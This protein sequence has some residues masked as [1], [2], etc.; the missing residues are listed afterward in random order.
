MPLIRT[1]AGGIVD[2]LLPLNDPLA[3]SPGAAQLLENWRIRNRTLVRRPGVV[4]FAAT[5]TSGTT[6]VTHPELPVLG[7]WGGPVGTETKL[8]TAT[9][10][11]TGTTPSQ[12]VWIYTPASDT[13]THASVTVTTQPAGNVTDL[14]T[15]CSIG[16]TVYLSN[17]VNKTWKWSGSGDIADVVDT[18]TTPITVPPARWLVG[19]FL[20]RLWLLHTLEG[21]ARQPQRVRWCI[22]GNVTNWSDSGAGYEDLTDDPF[23]IT[24]GGVISGRLVVYKG[25]GTGGSIVVGVPTGLADDPVGFETLNPGSG[26]G[27]YAPRTVQTVAGG[28]HIFLGH[29][30]VYVFDGASLL[31]VGH[32]VIRRVLQSINP[33]ALRWAWALYDPTEAEYELHIPL[34]AGDTTPSDRYVFNVRERRWSGYESAEYAHGVRYAETITDTWA[35]ALGAWNAQGDKR[36]IDTTSGILRIYSVYGTDTATYRRGDPAQD[37]DVGTSYSSIYVSRQHTFEGMQVPHG[38]SFRV[39]SFDDV[40]VLRSL[41]LIW[42]DLGAVTW[43]VEVSTDTGETWTTVSDGSARGSGTTRVVRTIF[44]CMISAT[45]F[46]V[47]V[48]AP[49]VTHLIDVEYEIGYAGPTKVPLVAENPP[50]GGTGSWIPGHDPEL[51]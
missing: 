44:G 19:G 48:T 9:Q 1:R 36:W 38:R 42:R 23:P 17:G 12:R 7:L 14:F 25:D 31:P 16:A 47:R 2:G 26:I 18:A 30:D 50:S 49:S 20:E 34:V 6:T 37:T 15:F 40:K 8:F 27:C 32:P 35:T 13:F 11:A 4:L 29:D 5:F 41:T 43:V 51:P 45:D 39:L 22:R 28:V 3:I 21:G 33:E 24:G 10:W 46:I